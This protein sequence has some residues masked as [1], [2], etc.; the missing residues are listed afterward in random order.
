M[1]TR[2][3]AVLA[4]GLLMALGP[5][6]AQAQYEYMQISYP[7]QTATQVFGINDSGD[8]VGTGVVPGNFPF[9]YASM[10]GTLTDIA[11]AAGYDSTGLIG[12]NDA[13]VIVG[14]VN[15]LG[16]ATTSAFIRSRDGTYTVFSHPDAMSFTSARGVNNRGLVTGFRDTAEGPRVGFIY[17]SRTETFTDIVPS[18][19]TIAHGINSKGEVVGSALF[20]TGLGADDPCGVPE[21]FGRYG[22]VRA[23][24]GS[25]TFFLVNGL[26]TRARGINDAGDIVGWTIDLNTGED[27]GFVIKVPETSCESIT[28]G[29]GEL[30][31]FPGSASTN[32]EGITN[33]G[34]IVGIYRDAS[35]QFQGFIATPQ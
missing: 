16:L 20:I 29:A 1:V 4:A 14:S 24:D 32:P 3:K 35:D 7:G 25:V 18:A 15:S 19:V 21:A 33:S 26:P 5:I 22:W 28:V 10:D 31:Q 9:I 23:R 30:L 17:D 13:G 2:M 6:A 8:V 27:K 11:P 12:I 34:D